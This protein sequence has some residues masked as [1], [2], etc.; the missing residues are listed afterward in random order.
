[1][2]DLVPD[3]CINQKAMIPIVRSVM[4]VEGG[5]EYILYHFIEFVWF[6][7]ILMYETN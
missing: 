7:L 3:K 2:K 1:M 4:F 5:V 6:V